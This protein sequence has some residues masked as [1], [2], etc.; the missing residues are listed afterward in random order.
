[1]TDIDNRMQPPAPA[2]GRNGR[3]EKIGEVGVDS[4]TIGITD[5]LVGTR[6]SFMRTASIDPDARYATPGSKWAGDWGT[7]VRFWAG[8][9]DGSYDVWAWI[10]DYGEDGEVDERIA[11][12]VVTM[13]DENDLA[14]WRSMP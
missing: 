13:I 4:A 9:G 2:M 3:W 12:V 8:F 1:M 7:G 6:D 11:Q 14:E 10:A 5:L